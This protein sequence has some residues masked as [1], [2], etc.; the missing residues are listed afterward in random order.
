MKKKL[1]VFLSVSLLLNIGLIYFFVFRG[2]VIEL[3]DNRKAIVISKENKEVVLAEMRSFLESVQ[4]I[5][6]GVLDNDAQ[7]II[8]AGTNAGNDVVEKVPKG[9]MRKLPLAFKKMG[10]ATHDLF[11]EISQEAKDHF[12]ARNTQNKLST[13][14][15]NC[16][17]CHKTY[18][19]EVE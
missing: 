3:E 2:E 9:L 4:Q 8:N 17:A 14:L 13:L 11:D 1:V 6:Q 15:N 5:N 16:V 12:N 19:L 10:F 7:M 18:K